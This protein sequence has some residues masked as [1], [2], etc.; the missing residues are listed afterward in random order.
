M[1]NKE[2]IPSQYRSIAGIYRCISGILPQDPSI[3]ERIP[4]ISLP[5][6]HLDQAGDVPRCKGFALVTLLRSEDVDYLL[7]RWPW[8]RGPIVPD[9]STDP[10]V[11][12]ALKH[13]LR[14]LQKARWD[15]LNSEYLQYRRQ[16]LEE[17]VEHE[18]LAQQSIPHPSPSNITHEVTMQIDEQSGRDT[19]SLTQPSSLDLSAPY[20]PGCL[21]HVRH[22][23]PETNKTTLRK[24]FAKAAPE[25]GDGIDYVDFNKGMTTVSA[26]ITLHIYRVSQAVLVLFASGYSKSRSAID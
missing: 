7:Q 25:E 14:M 23:H 5:K 24:L 4:S 16:L 15:Q 8:K 26:I 10:R 6:H 1:S 12:E 19:D 18:E 3:Q 2:N 21:V 20:P 11:H 17:A 13:G 22:I 9:D